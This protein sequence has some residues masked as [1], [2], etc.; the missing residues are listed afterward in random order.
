ML[1]VLAFEL[2]V[3]KALPVGYP[4]LAGL[5][6]SDIDHEFFAFKDSKMSWLALFLVLFSLSNGVAGY[7]ATRCIPAVVVRQSSLTSDELSEVRVA[8]RSRI[9]YRIQATREN[10]DFDP[11]ESTENNVAAANSEEEDDDELDVDVVVISTKIPTTDSLSWAIGNSFDDFLNQ[12][13]VQSFMFLLKTCRDPQTVLWI[14]R[15]TRPIIGAPPPA[16]SGRANLPM[17]GTSNSKLLSYHG[18]AAMNTTAFPTWES[19]FSQLMEQP[20]EFYL[21]ESNQAHIPSYEMDINPASLCARM[22]S[23]REQIAREFTK[24]LTIISS[25]GGQTLQA[26]WQGIRQASGDKNGEDPLRSGFA[27]RFLFLDA[28]HDDDYQPSPLRKGNFDLLM[29]LTTQESI[30][31]VL[32]RVTTTAANDGLTTA[33]R[34]FLSTFYLNRLVSHFTGRQRYGRA[35]QFLQELLLSNPSMTMSTGNLD[36]SATTDVAST[37]LVDPTRIAEQ[38]LDVRRD[39]AAEWA[40]RASTVP[41]LHVEI[42]RQ[43][44]NLLMK[45]YSRNDDDFQ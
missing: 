1:L 23:V 24:D 6:C 33:N 9:P 26:Y 28:D 12:C 17:G 40:Q 32:N 16:P 42:K 20:K 21:I 45:S 37:M 13:T 10:E 38:I 30:H 35:D 14:E 22:I 11:T 4:Y 41:E 27:G 15:F 34:R 29:L 3:C 25:M 18:L 19:Y 36:D 7:V 8:Q 31:R 39:V 44:L 43:Q 2:F 5:R